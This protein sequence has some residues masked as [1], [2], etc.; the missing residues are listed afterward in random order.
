MTSI[1]K[2]GLKIT[3]FPHFIWAIDKLFIHILYFRLFWFLDMFKILN[4]LLKFPLVIIAFFKQIH[5]GYFEIINLLCFRFYDIQYGQLRIF[6]SDISPSRL[7]KMHVLYR[8]RKYSADD[9]TLLKKNSFY[10]WWLKIYN[11]FLYI[12]FINVYCDYM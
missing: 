2:N 6:V 7:L 11:I 1:S 12:L 10:N 3:F 4:Y 8:N 5:H 9:F